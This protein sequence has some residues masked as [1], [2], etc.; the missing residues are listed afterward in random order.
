MQSVEVAAMASTHLGVCE[1]AKAGR[2][3]RVRLD[4][5]PST[6]VQHREGVSAITRGV[7]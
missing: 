4:P 5:Q 1:S 3:S 7:V 2:P 6:L